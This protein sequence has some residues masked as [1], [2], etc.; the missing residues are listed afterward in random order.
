MQLAR[1]NHTELG[2]GCVARSY[3]FDGNTLVARYTILNASLVLA[4]SQIDD[5]AQY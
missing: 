3:I 4:C 1:L 5:H 2:H